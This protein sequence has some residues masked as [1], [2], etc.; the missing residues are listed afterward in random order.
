MNCRAPRHNGIYVQCPNKAEINGLCEEH[1]NYISAMD[2]AVQDY[3]DQHKRNYTQAD[4]DKAQR[5]WT[6]SKNERDEAQRKYYKE[7]FAKR[8]NYSQEKKNYS[9]NSNN[10][11]YEKTQNKPSYFREVAPVSD[12]LV[13][14]GII[15][16][17][18]WKKWM[19]INHPDKG[20]DVELFK[21]VKNAYEAL[22]DLRT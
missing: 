15:S 7:R 21:L 16:K 14:H 11:N 17:K 19:L 20:G 13:K 12:I 22:K 18:T 5:E 8:K 1:K 10:T 2:K 4:A 9:Q 6:Q 3:D